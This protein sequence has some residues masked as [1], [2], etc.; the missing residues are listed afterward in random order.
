MSSSLAF[1]NLVA[2]KHYGR[3]NLPVKLALLYLYSASLEP[4]TVLSGYYYDR[5][6]GRAL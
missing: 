1:T 6:W 4:L 5:Y 2:F 3:L